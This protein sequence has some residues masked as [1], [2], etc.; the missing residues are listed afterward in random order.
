MKI[1]DVEKEISFTKYDKRIFSKDKKTS[2][3]LEII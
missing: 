2:T 1:E 3:A